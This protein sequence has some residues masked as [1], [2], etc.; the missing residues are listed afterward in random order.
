MYVGIIACRFGG[1]TGHIHT[2]GSSHGLKNKK[3]AFRGTPMYHH[4]AIQRRRPAPD[5]PISDLWDTRTIINV[6]DVV[7]V[8]GAPTARRPDRPHL[9]PASE[10]TPPP[11]P[12]G[13]GIST[14]ADADE[15]AAQ[16]ASRIQADRRGSRRYTASERQGGRRRRTTAGYRKA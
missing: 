5:L 15:R 16:G 7:A 9:L 3:A 6:D 13:G 2:C 8:G 4:R 1:R 12:L 10:G 14:T 11:R